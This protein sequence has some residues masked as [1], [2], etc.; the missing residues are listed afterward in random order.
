VNNGR[1]CRVLIVED[2][3][4]IS[5]LIE[6]MVSDLG[7]HVVGPAANIDQALA[8]AQ[9]ADVDLAVLDIGV[10]GSVVYP[11]ADVLRARSIPFIF[12]T[13]YDFNALPRGFQG[14][15]V[16]SKP[17]SYQTFRDALGDVLTGSC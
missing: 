17:F 4:M 7:C 15:R 9:Q 2:E 10:D 16:L 6:D 8:L 14:T 12:A 3:A 11:V 13:G 5:M 1:K